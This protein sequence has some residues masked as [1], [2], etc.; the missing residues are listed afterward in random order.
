MIYESLLLATKYEPSGNF[1][2]EGS[3]ENV[4]VKTLTLK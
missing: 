3:F 2:W 4:H 1:M